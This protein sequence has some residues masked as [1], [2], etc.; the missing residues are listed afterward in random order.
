MTQVLL[1]GTPRAVGGRGKG[2]RTK[3]ARR[4]SLARAES[5]PV[6]VRKRPVDGAES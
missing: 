2:W 4:R 1:S 3:R 6:P 5:R